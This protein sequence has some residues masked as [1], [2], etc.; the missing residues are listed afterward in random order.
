MD[1]ILLIDAAERYVKGEMTPQERTYFEEIRKNN[2]ELDQLVVEHIFFLNELDSFSHTRN[3]KHAL[4]ET[5]AK[6]IGDSIAIDI[7][8][9]R[10]GGFAQLIE[11]PCLVGGG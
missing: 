5:E 4:Q 3:F 10:L 1:D 8:G 7:F 9:Q 11:R 2:P 6:L